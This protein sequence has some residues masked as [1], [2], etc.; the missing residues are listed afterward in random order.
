MQTRSASRGD[1]GQGE[2]VMNRPDQIRAR[3]TVLNETLARL[4]AER[5]RL[6]ARATQAERKRDTRKK[7]LIG[8]AVLAAVAH[9]G[10]PAMSSAAELLAWLEPR[11][12]RPH[13]RDVCGAAR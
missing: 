8:G 3:L 1:D 4:H 10:V 6:Q 9:E 5:S 12:V 7:I 11:L 2:P 13:D